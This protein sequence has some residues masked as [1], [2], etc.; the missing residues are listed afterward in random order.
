MIPWDNEECS[1]FASVTTNLVAP[2]IR[3][4]P[5]LSVIAGYMY[6]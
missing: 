1:K 5:P 3:D 2:L 4:Q 6:V